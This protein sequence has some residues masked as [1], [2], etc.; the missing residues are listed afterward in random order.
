VASET[1]EEASAKSASARAVNF[2]NLDKVLWP[3]DGY[4]KGDL[5]AY[6]RAIAPWMLPY[7]RDRP[8]VLTRYPDGI[9]G[10]SFFQK[11]TP[12]FA[13]KWL[14]TVPIPD[15]DDG[16]RAPSYLVCDDVESLLYL[17]NSAS[18]PLHVWSSRVAALER[19]DW[20]ILDL[21]PKNAPFRHV[22]EV[23]LAARALCDEIRLP[24]YVKTSGSS[25]IHLL[26]P[27]GARLEHEQAKALGELLARVLVR[28]LP[29]IATITRQV[30]RRDGKVYIDY[31]QNGRGKLLVAPYCVRPLPGAPVSTP[32]RWREVEPGL[33]IRRFTIRSMLRR[34]RALKAD[35]L[36]PVLTESPDLL[37]ALDTL[38]GRI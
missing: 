15:G 6:Y 20:C 24:L 21:D 32:L 1:P 12:S 8:A 3:E 11:D 33:D 25:G 27:L 9:H 22:V 23:A 31:L 37:S 7:L 10:K 34:A 5:V 28:G 30:E 19:P 4:T 16:D 36:L 18:I 26:V 29:G 14:R 2:T 38:H 13:P 17:A 35:P